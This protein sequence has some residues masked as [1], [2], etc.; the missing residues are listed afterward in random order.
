MAQ[1]A[2][3]TYKNDTGVTHTTSNHEHCTVAVLQPL[4]AP[5]Y[6]SEFLFVS[7]QT[8]RAG[9]KE[10]LKK[11]SPLGPCTYRGPSYLD[12]IFQGVN[13]NP[14]CLWNSDALEAQ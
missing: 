5:R 9:I 3:L 7:I 4:A 1:D 11:W 14:R 10:G 13:T 8:D 6:T 2:F 12:V